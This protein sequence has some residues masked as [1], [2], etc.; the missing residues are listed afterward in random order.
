[1]LLAWPEAIWVNEPTKEGL[2]PQKPANATELMYTSNTV[3]TH[4]IE[5]YAPS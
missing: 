3:R 5:P 4:C 2:V 1:M